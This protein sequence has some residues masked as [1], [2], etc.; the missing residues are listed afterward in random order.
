[1]VN[2]IKISIIE[3]PKATLQQEHRKERKTISQRRKKKI[4]KREK[5]KTT[6]I[7]DNAKKEESR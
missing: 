4:N 7:G 5:R 6:E 3:K 2:V 1:M